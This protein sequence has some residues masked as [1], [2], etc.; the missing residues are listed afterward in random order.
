MRSP[1]Q[2]IKGFASGRKPEKAREPA[3]ES[4]GMADPRAED[5][6][7]YLTLRAELVNSSGT[8]PNSTVDVKEANW[9]PESVGLTVDL[10]ARDQSDP[11][12]AEPEQGG[13]LES[14]DQ[15]SPAAPVVQSA[16]DEAGTGVLTG[17][18][19]RQRE[20]AV[21]AQKSAWKPPVIT[22]EV[23][24]Q[25]AARETFVNEATELE[26]EIK[27]LR[28]QLSGKLRDQNAQLR[29]MLERYDDK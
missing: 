8:G 22:I 5:L 6:R 9:G 18:Q 26:I 7:A 4:V 17:G 14:R 20:N 3:D 28:S 10:P 19:K 27:V 24:E 15:P 21:R 13:S 1:W 16:K 11:L 2:L 25:R 12:L 29:R 23:E